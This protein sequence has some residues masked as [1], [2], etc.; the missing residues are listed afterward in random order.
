MNKEFLKVTTILCSL[1]A[2]PFTSIAANG[3]KAGDNGYLYKE[4]S[5]ESD[6]YQ[7]YV[8]TFTYKEVDTDNVYK[9]ENTDKTIGKYGEEG[10][11]WVRAD[12][13]VDESSEVSKD[14]EIIAESS[15]SKGGSVSSSKEESNL[16][17]KGGGSLDGEN[18]SIS[19]NANADINRNK[20]SNTDWEKRGYADLYGEDGQKIEVEGREYG[21]VQNHGDTVQVSS[22][23][24]KTITTTDKDGNT[25]YHT[26]EK[27]VSGEIDDEGAS[28]TVTTG[29]EE[30]PTSTTKID[31]SGSDGNGSVTITTDPYG[32]ATTNTITKTTDEVTGDVI[33]SGSKGNSVTKTS[34]ANGAVSYSGSGG[35]DITKAADGTLSSSMSASQDPNTG[36]VT[37]TGANNNSKTFT[38]SPRVR[39]ARW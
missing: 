17:A 4:A 31:A 32:N 26:F 10:D 23:K 24:S 36:D 18:K 7:T 22:S 1:S 20:G 15:S 3:E 39:K 19:A 28:L 35:N 33:V 37:V 12:K 2:L 11:Q 14:G 29:N 25:N 30:T 6:E 21:Y 5:G 27:G 13:T 8:K 38:P 9:R 34:Y 16:D